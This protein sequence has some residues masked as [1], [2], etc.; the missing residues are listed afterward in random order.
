M[1]YGLTRKLYLFGLENQE[2]AETI[3]TAG[4]FIQAQLWCSKNIKAMPEDVSDLYESLAWAYCNMKRNELLETFQISD[5]LSIDSL[6]DLANK[7]TV[8]FEAIKDDALPLAMPK[9]K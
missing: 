8:Y 5:E 2:S 9:K 4:D 3:A 7:V 6:N 1:K